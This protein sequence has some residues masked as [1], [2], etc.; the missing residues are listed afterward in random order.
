MVIDNGNLY[1]DYKFYNP[2][3]IPKK[4]IDNWVTG[5]LN[6]LTPQEAIDNLNEAKEVYPS[7]VQKAMVAFV[8]R[9]NEVT[10]ESK[11][12]F[13]GKLTTMFMIGSAMGVSPKKFVGAAMMY[14]F[15]DG[16]SGDSEESVSDIVLMLVF[17]SIA[18]QE[19]EM[20]NMWK[21][22]KDEDL[23]KEVSLKYNHYMES[24][25]I[26]QRLEEQK[27]Q[28]ALNNIVLKTTYKPTPW[29]KVEN[30]SKK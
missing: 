29:E 24:P 4:D 15:V 25:Y 8:H 16:L 6:G 13:I 3:D 12:S 10:E 7:T 14:T 23:K 1:T 21:K 9:R 5:E 28:A 17:L 19:E 26:K 27:I 30:I 18:K 22:I 11:C 2:Y 20:E